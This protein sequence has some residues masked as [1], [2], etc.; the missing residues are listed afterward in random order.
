MAASTSALGA[1]GGGKV[2]LDR[3]NS[4]SLDLR[5]FRPA[6]EVLGQHLRPCFREGERGGTSDPRDAAGYNNHLAFQ[7]VKHRVPLD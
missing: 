7:I 5:Q 4:G 3:C 2:E 6:A 1:A